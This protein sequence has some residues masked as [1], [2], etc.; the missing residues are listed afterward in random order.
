MAAKSQ[1]VT[2]SQA[3]KLGQRLR[4]GAP[5]EADLILLSAYRN[6]FALPAKSVFDVVQ[7]VSGL[8]PA[9]RSEK[10]TLSIVAKLRRETIKLSQMQDIAGCRVTVE[11]LQAQTTLADLLMQVFANAKLYDRCAKPVNGYR[12]KH[13]VVIHLGKLVEIQIRTTGQHSWALLS[14]QAADLFGQEVKYGIG[15]AGLLS[16]LHDVSDIIAK[17]EQAGISFPRERVMEIVHAA[18]DFWKSYP[19]YFEVSP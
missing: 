1:D 9:L 12:A 16:Q 8:Q 13:I 19:R 3:D 10:T 18:T 11:T 4:V 2:N 14:E 7:E 17:T 6:S 5:I 15:P